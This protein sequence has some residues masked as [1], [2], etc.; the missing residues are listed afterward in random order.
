MG[1]S[2]QGRKEPDRTE[3]LSMHTQESSVYMYHILFIHLSV[4]G[5]FS[6]FHTLLIINWAATGHFKDEKTESLKVKT[7]HLPKVT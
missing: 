7:G 5:H 4:D 6:C 3:S 2:L 1:Y